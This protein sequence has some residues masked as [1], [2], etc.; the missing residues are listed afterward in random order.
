MRYRVQNDDRTSFNHTKAAYMGT[1]AV[2]AALIFAFFAGAYWGRRSVDIEP[3]RSAM[4]AFEKDDQD[5][6]YWTEADERSLVESD[7][8]PNDPL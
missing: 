3:E 6:D 1:V 2:I 8:K 5:N 4:S 7:V